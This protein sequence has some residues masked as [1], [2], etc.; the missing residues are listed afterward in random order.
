MV[1]IVKVLGR[2]AVT[3][4]SNFGYAYERLTN[5]G[6]KHART[7]HQAEQEVTSNPLIDSL[8]YCPKEFGLAEGRERS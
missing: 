1:Y 3:S 8:N 7:E 4:A 6:T 5:G 2:N